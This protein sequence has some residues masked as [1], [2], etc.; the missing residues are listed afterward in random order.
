M[1]NRT[2]N[3]GPKTPLGR[4]NSLRNLRGVRDKIFKDKK[5]AEE[6]LRV[7]MDY[8]T[9]KEKRKATKIANQYDKV[10]KEMMVKPKSPNIDGLKQWKEEFSKSS[11][12]TLE[13]AVAIRQDI[14]ESKPLPNHF[15]ERPAVK[16]VYAIGIHDPRTVRSN[17]KPIG[18][19]SNVRRQKT[20]KDYY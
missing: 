4:L 19:W 13:D 5:Y 11:D 15:V 1:A 2:T 8:K 3:R 18:Q 10:F 17:W 7:G 9:Q 20:S 14:N 12:M 16:K 6:I